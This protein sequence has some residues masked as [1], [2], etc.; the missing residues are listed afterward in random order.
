MSNANSDTVSVIDTLQEEVVEEISVKVDEHEPLRSAPNALALG[1]DG[2][3]LYVALAGNSAI[4][5]VSLGSTSSKSLKK[6]LSQQE[7]LIPTPNQGA[8]RA[9]GRILQWITRLPSMPGPMWRAYPGCL[10]CIACSARAA[11][12]DLGALVHNPLHNLPERG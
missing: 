9:R 8:M 11:T 10:A 5:V 7:G 3:R 2:K 12:G 1:S 6:T 4:A